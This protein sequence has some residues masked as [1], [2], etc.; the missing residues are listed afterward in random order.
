MIATVVFLAEECMFKG[1]LVGDMQAAA[2]HEGAGQVFVGTRAWF[3]DM[4]LVSGKG[5]SL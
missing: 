2:M 4:E 1:M 5:G 3:K